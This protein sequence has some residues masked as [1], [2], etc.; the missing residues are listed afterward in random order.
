MRTRTSI[1]LD[2]E[3]HC[4]GRLLHAARDY[5]LATGYPEAHL[6]EEGFG[7]VIVDISLRRREAPTVGPDGA[8]PPS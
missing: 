4:R 3:N 6:N 8:L 1:E 2:H 5:L 7:N